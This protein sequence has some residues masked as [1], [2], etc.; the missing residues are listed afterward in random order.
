MGALTSAGADDVLDT[1]DALGWYAAPYSGDPAGAGTAQT[2]F[3]TV[4]V[5]LDS[6]FGTASSGSIA[7]DVALEWVANGAAT[8][9]W[10][11]IYDA[12]TDGNLVATDELD[13]SRTLVSGDT[14]R[15]AIGALTVALS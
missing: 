13:N 11:G 12:A 6:K 14:L 3:G 7:N 4:R 8:V 5:A 1:L 9:D 2:N 10:I 15:I